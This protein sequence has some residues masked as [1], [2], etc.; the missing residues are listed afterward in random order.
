MR[1]DSSQVSDDNDD[2][3]DVGCNYIGDGVPRNQILQLQ[4]ELLPH[5]PQEYI[6]RLRDLYDARDRAR[7]EEID[8]MVVQDG[9]VSHREDDEV[10]VED[11]ESMRHE[12]GHLFGDAKSEGISDDSRC[13][14]VSDYPR[15]KLPNGPQWEQYTL[16]NGVTQAWRIKS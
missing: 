3:G 13:D 15:S 5:D 4:E 7:G 10:H 12:E 8:D 11:G 1:F 14:M 2:D 9:Y 16:A 6:R